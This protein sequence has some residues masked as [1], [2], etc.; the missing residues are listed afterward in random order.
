MKFLTLKIKEIDEYINNIEDLVF[1]TFDIDWCNDDI[2][3]FTIDLIKKYKIKVTLFITHHTDIIK[4]LSNDDNIEIGI[5]PNFNFLLNGNFKYGKTIKE[6]IEYFLEIFPNAV[7]VRS[8]SLTQNTYILEE[9][10]KRGI[11]YDLNNF[12]PFFDKSIYLK[13]YKYLF[14]IIKIPFFFEDDFYLIQE[15]KK[16]IADYIN[17]KGLKVFNFHPIHIY[18]NTE[19]IERYQEAK[20]FLNSPKI[21]DF[22][23]TKSYGIRNLFIELIESIQ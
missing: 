16:N 23:N 18:L 6:I 22:I 1:M 8:H 2:L 9:L 5:H 19:R 21:R 13:P 11:K 4:D 20:K 17:Y 10:S 14:N 15:N 3:L 7:S 12:I